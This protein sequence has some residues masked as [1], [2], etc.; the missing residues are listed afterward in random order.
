MNFFNYW[1][2]QYSKTHYDMTNL[3]ETMS[4]HKSINFFYLQNS[5]F[6]F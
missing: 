2:N 5:N 3:V 6:T 4:N 1:N